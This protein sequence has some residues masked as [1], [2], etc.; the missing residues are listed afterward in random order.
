MKV[1]VTTSSKN[2][3]IMNAHKRQTIEN[4]IVKE[5]GNETLDLNDLVLGYEGARIVGAMIPQYHQGI[6]HIRVN[7]NNIDG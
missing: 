7:G 1:K 5:S 2:K 6:R 4:L 3:N